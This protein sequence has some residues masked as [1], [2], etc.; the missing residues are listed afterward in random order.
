MTKGRFR[1]PFLFLVVIPA[2]AFEAMGRDPIFYANRLFF[3]AS[4]CLN[5]F[6][7]RK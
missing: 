3:V 1:G 2:A 4:S 7:S 6:V 5:T